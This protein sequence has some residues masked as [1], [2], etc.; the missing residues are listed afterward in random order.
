M[1][2]CSHCRQILP[3]SEFHKNKA[4]RDG[5]QYVCKQ[6]HRTAKRKGDRSLEEIRASIFPMEGMKRCSKCSMVKPLSEYNQRRGDRGAQV[7]AYCKA[8]QSA[9]FK[10]W[11]CEAGRIGLKRFVIDREGNIRRVRLKNVSETRFDRRPNLFEGKC[12]RCER[13]LSLDQF[14]KASWNG[15]F[16]PT[17][18]DCRNEVEAHRYERL[19][20]H[21]FVRRRD[22]RAKNPEKLKEWSRQGEERRR[23]RKA[24]VECTLTDADWRLVLSVYGNQ[25][26]RCGSKE[27]VT[28]DHVVPISVGGPHTI[29]NVQPL[30]KSCNSK[31]HAKIMDYRPFL[32]MECGAPKSASI[33]DQSEVNQD[34]APF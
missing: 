21:Y 25:C 11:S 29:N 10:K 33:R 26:L 4:H 8:C 32:I 16:S 28:I 34:D 13:V 1:K 30:C 19:K 15:G 2:T 31:K 22:Y 23:A 17:C 12:I 24:A 27:G 6:C 5:L 9:C 3:L 14:H 7:R 18:A 20:A